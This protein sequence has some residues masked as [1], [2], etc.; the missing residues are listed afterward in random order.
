MR[1]YF[2]VIKKSALFTKK[3]LTARGVHAILNTP[4]QVLFFALIFHVSEKE[5]RMLSEGGNVSLACTKGVQDG[6]KY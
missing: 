2:P 5:L 1:E 3:N 6:T 4:M